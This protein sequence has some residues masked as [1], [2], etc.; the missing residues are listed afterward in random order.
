MDTVDE[1]RLLELAEKIEN[2]TYTGEELV[3]FQKLFL[4]YAKEVDNAIDLDTLKDQL[5]NSYK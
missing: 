2:E 4:A 1:K 5:H 3:E